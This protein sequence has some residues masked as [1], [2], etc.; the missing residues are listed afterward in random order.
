M[1]GRLRGGGRHALQV[2]PGPDMTTPAPGS[3]TGVSRCAASRLAEGPKVV[4]RRL[5]SH[6]ALEGTMAGPRRG[7]AA[8]CLAVELDLMGEVEGR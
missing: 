6:K 2:T 8:R 5:G 3:G 1:P 7:P 4:P